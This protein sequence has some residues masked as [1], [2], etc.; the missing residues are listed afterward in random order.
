MTLDYKCL[1]CGEWWGGKASHSCKEALE[2]ARALLV[3]MVHRHTVSFG[4]KWLCSHCMENIDDCGNDCPWLRA[5]K[6]LERT[7]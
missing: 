1:H 5:R 4:S 6:Y 2:E 7:R 3:E